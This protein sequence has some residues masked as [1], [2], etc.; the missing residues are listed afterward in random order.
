MLP[1]P[2]SE[3]FVDGFKLKIIA[4]C[5]NA[6]EGLSG[7]GAQLLEDGFLKVIVQNTGTNLFWPE[8]Y[9]TE[10][11]I[12]RLR[13]SES[14]PQIHSEFETCLLGSDDS[15]VFVELAEKELGG[16]NGI[17]LEIL[18]ES[19]AYPGK[20]E[21]LSYGFRIDTHEGIGHA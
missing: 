4:S 8:P 15:P 13:H 11:L 16:K 21:Y 14:N 20:E 3:S 17:W 18:C 9:T 19:P 5:S 2:E 1:T 10:A 7:R 12:L 6:A